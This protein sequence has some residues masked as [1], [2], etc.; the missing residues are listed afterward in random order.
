MGKPYIFHTLA[1]LSGSL[2]AFHSPHTEL[3]HI[4]LQGKCAG[5]TQKIAVGNLKLLFSKVR[6]VGSKSMRKK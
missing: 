5:F 3:G 6:I 4:P 1:F 2:K